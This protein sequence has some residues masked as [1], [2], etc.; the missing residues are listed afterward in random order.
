MMSIDAEMR[1]SSQRPKTVRTARM[2]PPHHHHHHDDDDLPRS[3]LSPQ[4]MGGHAELEAAMRD[5]SG[6]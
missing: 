3:T 5:R 6:L 1:A 2:D 4:R